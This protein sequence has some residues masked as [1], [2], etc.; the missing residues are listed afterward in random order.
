M[1]WT[2]QDNSVKDIEQKVLDGYKPTGDFYKD[3]RDVSKLVGI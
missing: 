3:A 1:I 2:F